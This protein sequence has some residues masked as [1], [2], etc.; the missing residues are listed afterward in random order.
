MQDALIVIQQRALPRLVSSYDQGNTFQEWLQRGDFSLDASSTSVEMLLVGGSYTRLLEF[1]GA[2]YARFLFS[3]VES[4]REATR[5]R[6]PPS[7]ASW[8]LIALYYSTYYGAQSVCRGSGRFMAR[9]EAPVAKF[10]S[11]LASVLGYTVSAT[12]G[13]YVVSVQPQPY[14]RVTVVLTKTSDKK[15]GGAHEAFWAFFQDFV[16]RIAQQAVE[17]KLGNAREVV[18][19]VANLQRLLKATNNPKGNYLS[20]IRNAI[21]YRHEYGG[22]FPYGLSASDLD[23][24]NRVSVSHSWMIR[25]DANADTYPIRAFTD[26]AQILA[27]FAMEVGGSVANGVG[28]G[29]FK[30]RLNRVL[31]GTV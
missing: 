1:L 18:A 26:T 25:T 6:D 17:L 24:L 30:R 12:A 2:D 21:T 8:R 29:P 22:W 13:N 11:D 14:D 16:G 3:S 15:E 7:A 9:V 4:F 10:L 20:S 31:A 23:Q 28:I 19:D 27:N 5:R